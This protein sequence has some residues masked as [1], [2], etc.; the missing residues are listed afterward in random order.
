MMTAEQVDALAVDDPSRR[1]MVEVDGTYV[2]ASP[3][4]SSGQGVG[5]TVNHGGTLSNVHYV[6]ISGRFYIES[7]VFLQGP[8]ELLSDYGSAYVQLYLRPV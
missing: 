5:M 8:C 4:A 7:S 1:Y 6:K 2:V 3:S